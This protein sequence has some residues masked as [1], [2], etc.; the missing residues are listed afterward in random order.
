M[1]FYLCLASLTWPH[2][3][4]SFRNFN[5]GPLLRR[6]VLHDSVD[7]YTDL[8]FSTCCLHINWDN[9]LTQEMREQL[10]AIDEFES[11]F[12]HVSGNVLP[13]ILRRLKHET[14]VA[15]VGASTRIEGSEMTD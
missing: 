6:N 8:T 12:V 13:D 2:V 4:K 15:S 11:K 7:P 14:G 5:I 1:F 9:I 3:A 10:S